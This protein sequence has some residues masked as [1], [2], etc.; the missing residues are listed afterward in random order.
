MN[1]D[2]RPTTTHAEYRKLAQDHCLLIATNENLAT[3]YWITPLHYRMPQQLKRYHPAAF[4]AAGPR[5]CRMDRKLRPSSKPPP[6]PA[7]VAMPS[8]HNGHLAVGFT[9]ICGSGSDQGQ[10]FAQPAMQ[11]LCMH[12]H[13]C[14]N[15]VAKPV[16]KHYNHGGAQMPHNPSACSAKALATLAN[17]NTECPSAATRVLPSRVFASR[18]ERR[19]PTTWKK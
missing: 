8:G 15:I 6:P 5:P 18:L 1:P 13:A 19:F 11:A 16:R 2:G 4:S 14:G 17:G 9:R 7:L 12:V 3:F 10:P